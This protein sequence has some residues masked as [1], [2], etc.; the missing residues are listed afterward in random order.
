MVYAGKLADDS[1]ADRAD[2][3]VREL[4]GPVFW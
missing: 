1:L 3:L 2:E 4:C